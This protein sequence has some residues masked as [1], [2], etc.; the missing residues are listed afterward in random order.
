MF[1]VG[2]QVDIPHVK[3]ARKG[4]A[5][6]PKEISR[7]LRILSLLHGRTQKSVTYGL[8]YEHAELIISSLLLAGT[9]RQTNQ[10]RNLLD[11]INWL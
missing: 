1:G 8:L 2:L 7:V 4:I 6:V 10:P 5:D 3:L 11:S 9:Q